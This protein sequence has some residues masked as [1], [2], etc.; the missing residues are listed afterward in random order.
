MESG[1]LANGVLITGID[2]F[3]AAFT[4]IYVGRLLWVGLC[5]HQDETGGSERTSGVRSTA[6][7]YGFA[8]V[9]MAKISLQGQQVAARVR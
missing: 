8:G 9:G 7:L 5:R 3:T 1:M 6:G 4:M 2:F